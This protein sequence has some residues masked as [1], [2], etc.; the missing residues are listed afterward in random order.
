[1]GVDDGDGGGVPLGGLEVE[2]SEMLDGQAELCQER[3]GFGACDGEAGARGGDVGQLDVVHDDE[4]V[5]EGHEAGEL[6]GGGLEEEGVGCRRRC[7]RRPGCG[8]AR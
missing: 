3:C 6:G 4:A 2:G 7:R 8:P 5:E 1:M